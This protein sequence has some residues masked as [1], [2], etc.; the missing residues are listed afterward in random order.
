MP[1]PTPSRTGQQIIQD[2]RAKSAADAAAAKAAEEANRNRFLQ[3]GI[4]QQG[5]MAG[6]MAAGLGSLAGG[7]P[8][9][10]EMRGR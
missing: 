7:S 5:Q 8:I 10:R 3:A 6:S 1:Q 9:T 4:R 2:R